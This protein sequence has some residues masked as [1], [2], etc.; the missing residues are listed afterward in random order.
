[1]EIYCN[2]VYVGK[3]GNNLKVFFSF[4]VFFNIV[5]NIYY[6][7]SEKKCSFLNLGRFFNLFD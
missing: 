3:I 7:I 4:S 1:M 2:I 6:F 5:M